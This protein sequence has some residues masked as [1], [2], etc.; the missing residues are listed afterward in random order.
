MISIELATGKRIELSLDEFVE[1][2]EKLRK[3]SQRSVLDEIK[4]NSCVKTPIQSIQKQDWPAG[5]NI[6]VTCSNET[7]NQ[8]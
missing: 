4:T 3:M 6:N 1:L 8:D 5:R 2:N 7:H